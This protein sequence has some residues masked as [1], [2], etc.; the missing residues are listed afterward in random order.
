MII[1][2]DCFILFRNFPLQKVPERDPDVGSGRE[3][4]ENPG[5]EIPGTKKI[6]KVQFF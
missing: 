6:A 3:A 1:L 2:F 5:T 4:E